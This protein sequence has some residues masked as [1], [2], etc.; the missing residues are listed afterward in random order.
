MY[1]LQSPASNEPVYIYIH[2]PKN[3]FNVRHHF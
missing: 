3:K 2:I 1:P